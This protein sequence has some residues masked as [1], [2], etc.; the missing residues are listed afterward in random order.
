MTT[1]KSTV[2][3]NDTYEYRETLK[4]PD[5]RVSI[6]E[7]G[8]CKEKVLFD[9]LKKPWNGRFYHTEDTNRFFFDYN[10]KRYELNLFG[11]G[12]GGGEVIDLREYAKKTDL[13]NYAKKT[14]LNDYAKKSELTDFAKKSELNDYAKKTDLNTYAKK[15][16]LN[17]YAKKSELPTKTSDLTNDSNF[18][19]IES[20]GEFLQSNGYITEEMLLDSI[21][22]FVKV[23][24]FENLS[25][26]V[27][28][29]SSE[30]EE[31]K[32]RIDEISSESDSDDELDS[33]RRR[34]EYL[35]EFLDMETTWDE[36]SRE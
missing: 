2:K 16:D 33:L 20:V 6:M 15:T 7:I 22:G 26:R 19:T 31:I 35:E 17:D 13:K 9:E 5:L 25:A 36:F 30:I 14:D 34:I 12:G 3:R 1:K 4:R 28:D 10:N 24:D 27:S 23:E 8:L 18:I 32:R 21:S 11:G 29:M